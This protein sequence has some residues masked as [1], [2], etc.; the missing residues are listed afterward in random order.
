M[1]K[2]ARA[3]KPRMAMR[4]PWAKLSRFCRKTPGTVE[5]GLEVGDRGAAD[6]AR[7]IHQTGDGLLDILPGQGRDGRR[8]VVEVTGESR[9]GHRDG[10][11]ALAGRG[12]ASVLLTVWVF[13]GLPPGEGAPADQQQERDA[14]RHGL[15]PCY[16]YGE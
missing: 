14:I 2:G 11:Q 7:L 1:P 15:I 4:W 16:G 5:R 13:V 6:E 3:P 12:D 10:G 8:G 9:G